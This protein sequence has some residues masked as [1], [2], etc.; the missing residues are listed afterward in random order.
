[1]TVRLHNEMPRTFDYFI[2][3]YFQC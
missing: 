1:M 2:G 3:I